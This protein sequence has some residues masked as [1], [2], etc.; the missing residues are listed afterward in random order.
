MERQLTEM[1]APQS[2]EFPVVATEIAGRH[3]GHVQGF[4]YA[5]AALAGL[6][7]AA[8]AEWLRAKNAA[9]GNAT[10]GAAPAHPLSRNLEPEAAAATVEL[11][12]P[13]AVIRTPED[14]ARAV[15]APL[16]GVVRRHAG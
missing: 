13:P 14:A 11:P 16:I 5:V 1:L 15:R 4:W 2:A 9:S 10:I 7:V 6:I 3:L 8:G 12:P